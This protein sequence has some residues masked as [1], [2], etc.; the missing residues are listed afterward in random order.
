MAVGSLVAVGLIMVG[1]G[2]AVVNRGVTVGAVAEVGVVRVVGVQA[3]NSNTEINTINSPKT[4]TI[5]IF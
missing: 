3:I 5:E 4:R 1:D 2:A